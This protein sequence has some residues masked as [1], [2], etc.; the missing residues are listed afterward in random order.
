[1][2]GTAWAAV[3][4]SPGA[5]ALSQLAELG[6]M[7]RSRWVVNPVVVLVLVVL[8]HLIERAGTG[9]AVASSEVDRKVRMEIQD[10]IVYVSLSVCLS[11]CLKGMKMINCTSRLIVP[12]SS[13]N[14]FYNRG[15]TNA[16]R[17]TKKRQTMAWNKK[18]SP[19]RSGQR[20]GEPRGLCILSNLVWLG[21]CFL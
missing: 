1:M 18:K 4:H 10:R 16:C 8:L 3:L 20:E 7:V 15:Q 6:E 17:A 2:K 11:V 21:D 5:G 9:P 14:S 13:L 19:S 12:A